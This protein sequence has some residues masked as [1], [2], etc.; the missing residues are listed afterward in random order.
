MSSM[1]VMASISEP[2][3]QWKGKFLQVVRCG[4]W[5]Y[6]ERV[7]TTGAV[8][9]VSITANRE[10]ILTEQYR[11]PVKARVLELPAGLVG[12]SPGSRNE[13]AV[14]GARRELMEETGYAAERLVSAG[15]GP[16][17]AGFGS[18]VV[19][20]FIATGLRKIGVGGGEGHEEIQV[21]EVS[22]GSLND[23]LQARAAEGLLVDP[24]IYAGVYLFEQY[25]R[26]LAAS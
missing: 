9:I 20:F 18:E 19:E 10:L 26:K 13:P 16:P 2:V 6:A 5:E 12:D 14:E 22:L 24:K 7:G 23:W 21:H 17:S 25:E 1:R 4:H 8:A 11:I 3:L 15:S